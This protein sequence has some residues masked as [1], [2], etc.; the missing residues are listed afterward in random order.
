MVNNDAIEMNGCEGSDGQCIWTHSCG[1]TSEKCFADIFID[2][3]TREIARDIAEGI[4][5]IT[6]ACQPSEN[7]DLFAVVFRINRHA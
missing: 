1:A 4:K 6:G 2:E 3:Y 5:A 7:A